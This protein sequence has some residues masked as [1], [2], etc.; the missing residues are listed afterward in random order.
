MNEYEQ[1]RS[2]VGDFERCPAQT[3]ELFQA[4]VEIIRIGNTKIAFTVRN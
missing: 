1:I 4:D 3:N 2:L